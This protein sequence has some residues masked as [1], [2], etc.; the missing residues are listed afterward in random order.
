MDG[1]LRAHGQTRAGQTL[2]GGGS[3]G[4]ALAARAARASA[5]RTAAAMRR[6]ARRS[7][8]S[9]AEAR[10]IM[11]V[12]RRFK[13][14]G[15]KT[16]R[17]QR[18]RDRPQHRPR[19]AADAPQPRR[20]QAQAPRVLPRGVA[21]RSWLRGHLGVVLGVGRPHA[22]FKRGRGAGAAP[23][24]EPAVEARVPRRPR[25][26]A[27]VEDELGVHRPA[28]GEPPHG[29]LAVDR[30]AHGAQPTWP[31]VAPPHGVPVADEP[32]GWPAAG[33]RPDEAKG[34][35]PARAL[36]RSQGLARE[37]AQTELRQAAARPARRRTSRCGP[38]HVVAAARF[39]SPQFAAI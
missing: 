1:P 16:H 10:L 23:R 21:M 18:A 33:P 30:D 15:P 25:Q 2:P 28:R 34:G 4:P 5:P 20:V 39:N 6:R 19:L 14:R 8:T 26:H 17:G 38:P 9:L 22:R 13:S 29:G 35:V 27:G 11:R 32:E 31:F 36:V 37:G 3:D 24:E 12:P 7:G